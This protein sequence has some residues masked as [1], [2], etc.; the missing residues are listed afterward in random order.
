MIVISPIN[1]D[2]RLSAFRIIALAS[3][4]E[5][6]DDWM[7]ALQGVLMAAG[8]FP[9]L[10]CVII[11]IA[12]ALKEK[13]SHDKL[14]TREDALDEAKATLVAVNAA[15]VRGNAAAGGTIGGASM[16]SPAMGSPMLGASMTS[17]S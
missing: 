12:Y 9:Y 3:A 14:R 8:A 17:R 15:A 4:S 7:S 2:P 11:V 6:R 1:D 5:F 10:V 16:G 13:R